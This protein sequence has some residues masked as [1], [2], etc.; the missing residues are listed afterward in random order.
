MDEKPLKFEEAL[1]RLEKVVQ[2]MENADTSLEDSISLYKE[3]AAL[4]KLCNEILN[5]FETEVKMLQC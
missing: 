1:S 2:T 3:G 5:K 4:S